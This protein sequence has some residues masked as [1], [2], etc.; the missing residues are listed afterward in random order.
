[1]RLCVR[2]SV[3]RSP[4][5]TSQGV[6]SAPGLSAPGLALP[7]G[8]APGL[9]AP[10]LAVPPDG[11]EDIRSPAVVRPH[12]GPGAFE[13]GLAQR[14][15]LPDQQVEDAVAGEIGVDDRAGVPAEL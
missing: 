5:L 1:M 3:S 6:P 8:A 15:D 4:G 12:R 2:S 11:L 13:P 10:G 14:V 9:P 7:G